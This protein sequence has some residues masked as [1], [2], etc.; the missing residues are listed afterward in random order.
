MPDCS[1]LLLHSNCGR[2]GCLISKNWKTVECTRIRQ[3]IESRMMVR[4]S[5]RMT[6][7][8]NPSIL[9]IYFLK[10]SR[11][12]VTNIIPIRSVHYEGTYYTKVEIRGEKLFFFFQWKHVNL[13]II[14]SLTPCCGTTLQQE[15]S[16]DTPNGLEGMKTFFNKWPVEYS[17][18]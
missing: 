3:S 17:K 6:L 14:S 1:Y 9:S 16:W 18:C 2:K 13:H 15:S 7:G 11:Q 4:I 8:C 10:I 5:R 12:T